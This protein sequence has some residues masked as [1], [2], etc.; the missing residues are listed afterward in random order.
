MRVVDSGIGA[1]LDLILARNYREKSE[2]GLLVK[3]QPRPSLLEREDI[4]ATLATLSFHCKVLL[5]QQVPN[6]TPLVPQ[7]G[8]TWRGRGRG[9]YGKKGQVNKCIDEDMEKRQTQRIGLIT[10]TRALSVQLP[11]RAV[12][13][14]LTTEGLLLLLN[15]PVGDS[16][17][18]GGFEFAVV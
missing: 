7:D 4:L 17:G 18:G 16:R 11:P 9:E 13:S 1:V 3:I 8:F 14:E 2:S 5:G 6:A 15:G 10:A 12:C